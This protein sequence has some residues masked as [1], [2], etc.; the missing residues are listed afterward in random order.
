MLD[1]AIASK[2][3]HDRFLQR[4]VASR[5]TRLAVAAA[6]AGALLF[7]FLGPRPSNDRE[8][9]SDQARL[10]RADFDGRIVRVQDLRYARYRSTS[11]FDLR[12]EDRTY[13]L[14]RLRSAWFVVEPF[15][16]WGGP[17]HTLMTFG[18]EGDDYLAVSVEIR[19]ERGEQFS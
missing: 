17:A 19:K 13:D 6:M 1:L 15:A 12:W 8:W 2:E 7:L 5:F 16:D 4:I 18:F 14:D 11:D 9:A 3:R 10:P